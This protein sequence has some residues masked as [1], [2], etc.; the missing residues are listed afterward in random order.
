MAATKK[1]PHF[2]ELATAPTTLPDPFGFRRDVSVALS[3]IAATSNVLQAKALRDWFI[4]VAN[5]A[6][7]IAGGTGSGVSGGI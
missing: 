4:A 2:S 6:D 1:N 5:Q 7:L 3:Q